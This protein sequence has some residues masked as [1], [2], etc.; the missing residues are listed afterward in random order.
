M[1]NW[2]L[3][4]LALSL[5]VTAC[6][7]Y[8]DSTSSVRI[9]GKKE[10]RSGFQSKL[11]V[12]SV[13]DLKTCYFGEI[14]STTSGSEK[15]NTSNTASLRSALDISAYFSNWVQSEET[16]KFGMT[17]STVKISY[18]PTK[19]G[20]TPDF[21][22]QHLKHPLIK[23][24]IIS[25]FG[26]I[27]D[28]Y[29]SSQNNPESLEFPL[30][31]QMFLIKQKCSKV[32]SQNQI[33]LFLDE[34]QSDNIGVNGYSAVETDNQGPVTAS[35]KNSVVFVSNFLPEVKN[36]RFELLKSEKLS[37]AS[38]LVFKADNENLHIFAYFNK[39]HD[40]FTQSCDL[41]LEQDLLVQYKIQI[42]ETVSAKTVELDKDFALNIYE[43]YSK[44]NDDFSLSASLESILSA[45]LKT[46]AKN[47][48]LKSKTTTAENQPSFYDY[49]LLVDSIQNTANNI[50][51]KVAEDND[52]TDIG[53]D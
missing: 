53:D 35:S 25:E 38:K 10:R 44:D 28:I 42:T 30:L 37:R 33:Q 9:R 7:D 40:F 36:P 12:K 31:S 11:G 45:N 4:M 27:K 3:S 24:F 41:K 49:D 34:K 39:D 21:P 48:R 46:T 8:Q 52:W 15:R 50:C 51:K 20:V 43:A 14:K 29:D 1:K 16:M 13:D 19:D 2:V 22:N 6:S 26:L 23:N 32:S 47:S 17:A 5:A 18:A